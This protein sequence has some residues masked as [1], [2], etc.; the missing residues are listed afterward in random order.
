MRAAQLGP[1]AVAT[2]VAADGPHLVVGGS[3]GLVSRWRATGLPGKRDRP[4]AV[5]RGHGAPISALA[6]SEALDLSVSASTDGSVLVRLWSR[7]T[8]PLAGRPKGRASPGGVMREPC[9]ILDISPQYRSRVGQV[10]VLS[11]GELLRS[12]PVV[13][14]EGPAAGAVVTALAISREGVIA[15]LPTIRDAAGAPQFAGLQASSSTA[16]SHERWWSSAARNSS[17]RSR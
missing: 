2:C 5:L 4:A 14:A 10:H 6:I 17:G 11:T 8:T 15:A 7:R 3:D 12:L 9:L 13:P 1:P 16:H